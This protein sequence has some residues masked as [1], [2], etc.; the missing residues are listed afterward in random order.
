MNKKLTT[1]MT[2]AASAVAVMLLSSCS[3][4]SSGNFGGGGGGGGELPTTAQFFG[5]AIDAAGEFA[6]RTALQG[7]D[8][9]APTSGPASTGSL[10]QVSTA[11]ASTVQIAVAS[12]GD[13]LQ[14]SWE[15]TLSD[16]TGPFFM[17]VTEADV[18][19][20]ARNPLGDEFQSIG[21]LWTPEGVPN[22]PANAGDYYVGI[23]TDFTPDANGEDSDYLAG[24]FW[25]HLPGNQTDIVSFGAFADGNSP[26]SVAPFLSG[27]TS[28]TVATVAV[29]SGKAAGLCDCAAGSD[30]EVVPRVFSAD[31]ALS[32][33][34][35]DSADMIEGMIDGFVVDEID[36]GDDSP[37]IVLEA[38]SL[39]N[40]AVG[41]FFTGTTTLEGSAAGNWGGMFYGA[42]ATANNPLPGS[43][44]GTFG[45][46]A[47]GE[48][49]VGAFGA[50]RQ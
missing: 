50:H 18:E 43:V 11:A 9:T 3:S 30:T 1:N 4:S 8:G 16:G 39:T 20:Q 34:F 45:A 41:G 7:A 23:F 24:G 17:E 6:V 19:F 33:S 27:G 37:T 40:D 35:G 26:F 47:G 38:A 36:L 2:V 5:N 31:A 29:F 28:E 48:T 13:E 44:G 15:L 21:A 32:V 46:S 14:Y 10:S 22:A 25:L 49:F 42:A 12:N